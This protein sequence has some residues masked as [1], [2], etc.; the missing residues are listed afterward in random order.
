[1]KAMA[2][3]PDL[4]LDIFPG[5]FPTG[6]IG[7]YVRDLCAALRTL[8]GGPTYRFAH[9]S[10]LR[11]LALARYRPDELMELPVNGLVMRAACLATVPFGLPLDS[12][13]GPSKLFH[14]PLGDGPLRSNARLI[15]HVHDLTF[16]QHPE[17]HPLRTR[18]FLSATVP[19]AARRADR[20]ICH[21]EWVKAE[22]VRGIGVRPERITV[23]PPPV[24]HDFHP[25]PPAVARAHVAWR[26]GLAAEYFLHV[27]TVEPRK[28][29]VRLFE[30]F[31]KLR[32]E[33]FPG[34][35]VLVGKNGWG[36]EP[37]LSRLESSS[38]R[39]N[40]VRVSDASE[41]DLVALYGAATAVAFPSL[42][43]G[44]GMPILEAMACGVPCVT[45]DRTGMADL[46]AGFA[47]LVTP[48]SVDQIVEALRRIWRDGTFR[49]R[50]AAEGP[51]RAAEYTLE[52]WAAKTFALYRSELATAEAGTPAPVVRA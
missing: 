3:V 31:E 40:I 22:V 13:Y 17:W 20:V 38:E 45:G 51:V 49:E 7:R 37:V 39:A 50:A 52:R 41:E 18:F 15:S 29:H 19:G 44:F 30:A 33:G 34:P 14:S 11:H 23:I 32:R 12:L 47:E 5:L 2:Q 35:L 25:V 43:E 10:N 8:P 21:S 6:G 28:N 16:L 1:M 36:I 9:T 27:G 26:F 24:G 46:G 42:E 4:A 48:E